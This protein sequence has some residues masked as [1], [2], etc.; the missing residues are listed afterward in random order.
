MF[1]YSNLS[2]RKKLAV[3]FGILLGSILLIGLF[4][5]AQMAKLNGATK[6]MAEKRMYEVRYLTT[7]RADVNATRRTELTWLLVSSKADVAEYDAKL[8]SALGKLLQD[9]KDGQDRFQAVAGEEDRQ[10]YQQ[11]QAALQNCV[12]LH[13]QVV[14]L[15]QAGKEDE[16]RRTAISQQPLIDAM[17]EAIDRVVV[18][19]GKNSD[20]A[21]QQ[22]ASDYHTARV[23]ALVVLAL[24]ITV[25]IVLTIVVS[26]S[27]ASPLGILVAGF[28]RGA[29]GDLTARI[30]VT[31]EDEVGQTS[32]AF[33]VFMEGLEGVLQQVV[34]TAER[35]ASA[36]EEISASAT[37]MANGGETQKDQVH[38]VATAMQEMAATVHEVSDNCNKA[39]ESAH[40]ASQTAREG[41]LIVEDTLTLMRSIADSVR[42]SATSVQEL[43]S[44][45]DQIGKIVGVIDDIADQT[46][47]LALNAA[48][49]AARAGEQGRGFAVVADEVR[50]LAERTTKATKEIAE[51]IQSVQAET[52]GAVG[53]MQ[54]GTQQV[55]KGVEVTA[56][57][58]VSLKQIIGEAEHVGEMV[59]QIATA[60]NEQS[61]ATEQVSSNM[62][63]IN[64]LVTE[65]A[66]GA[67]QSA[68]ACE[69]LSGLA[70]ELQNLVSR[71]QLGQQTASYRPRQ[72]V[73]DSGRVRTAL[74]LAPRSP[75]GV[76]QN[77]ERD[78]NREQEI[79][80]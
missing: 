16:A 36:S 75:R 38:Q 25:G 78:G 9:I 7:I 30:A 2:I 50:K 29:E 71:F 57:A 79:Y 35:V 32:R 45:S 13:G 28:S 60:A 46:N 24:A 69:Q 44:R 53:K 42:D 55:E 26:R 5:L 23:F 39:S 33:N 73:A 17:F 47:L 66:E 68:K 59:T 12:G 8:A 80:S 70:L 63:Q 77:V 40:K 6:D 31:S 76:V 20:A 1:G 58:G 14:S 61:S 52:R 62:E 51:M 4:S 37:Q 18:Q 65:S 67:Q 19:S 15:R 41:G 22:A 74:A 56:K 11:F 10:L 48:I 27:I 3:G 34:S 49:E 72:V 43:G 54:S 64:K 21:A